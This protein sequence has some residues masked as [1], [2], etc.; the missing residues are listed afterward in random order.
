MPYV[1]EGLGCAFSAI[2]RVQ[3]KIMVHTPITSEEIIEQ[4]FFL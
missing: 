3:M 1:L 4:R 2:V